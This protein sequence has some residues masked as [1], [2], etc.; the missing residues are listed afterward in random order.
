MDDG[1]E[2]DIG[3]VGPHGQGAGVAESGV[4]STGTD[5]TNTLRRALLAGAGGVN[6]YVGLLHV[7]LTAAMK[8][9]RAAGV[10]G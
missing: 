7:E 10:T 6:A 3:V 2:E 9:R 5:A 8:T 4:P 1:S